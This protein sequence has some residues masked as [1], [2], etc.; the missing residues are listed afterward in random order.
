MFDILY[1]VDEAIEDDV[2]LNVGFDRPWSL[3]VGFFVP[4]NELHFSGCANFFC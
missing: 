1:S 4:C 3:T 2:E